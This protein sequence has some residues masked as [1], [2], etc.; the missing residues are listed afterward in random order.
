[1]KFIFYGLAAWIAVVFLKAFLNTGKRNPK[2][3][4]EG[5]QVFSSS[6]NMSWLLSGG[7]V[8]S[9][10]SFPILAQEQS[11]T[12]LEICFAKRAVLGR[13]KNIWHLREKQTLVPSLS[14][15]ITG[16]QIKVSII[17][18]AEYGRAL[19]GAV[20]QA[21]HMVDGTVTV[22]CPLQLA[23]QAIDLE[24]YDEMVLE[25]ATFHF[26]KDMLTIE[27][28]EVTLQLTINLDDS[29]QTAICYALDF[30]DWCA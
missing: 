10:Q 9:N 5:D 26:F 1:M 8:L 14:L 27:F 6:I 15:M 25:I 13:P 11:L 3:L 2:R 12:G 20:L 17:A 18:E 4:K 7:R 22:R 19:A 21:L 24:W 28:P 16:E 23:L 30:A 29:T